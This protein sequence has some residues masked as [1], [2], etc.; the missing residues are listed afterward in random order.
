MIL[1]QELIANATKARNYLHLSR[2]FEEEGRLELAAS[3][4]EKGMNLL[5]EVFSLE[6]DT[7]TS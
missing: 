5:R 2:D 3:F 6:D 1:P 7:L 4:K